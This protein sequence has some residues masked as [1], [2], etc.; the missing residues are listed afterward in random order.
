MYT[1]NGNL[2]IMK[3]STVEI[4]YKFSTIPIAISLGFL[5]KMDSFIII[6]MEEKM[7]KKRKNREGKSILPGIK[8]SCS[9]GIKNS[10]TIN[11]QIDQWN[12]TVSAE[13]DP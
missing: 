2:Y 12:R 1:I 5:V 10:I 8:T 11:R 4:I 7:Q 9:Y 13:T 6:H 3:I